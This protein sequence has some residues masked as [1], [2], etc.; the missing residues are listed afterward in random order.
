MN[1]DFVTVTDGPFESSDILLYQYYRDV[2]PELTQEWTDKSY[3]IHFKTD[4]KFEKRGF[5]AFYKLY[6]EREIV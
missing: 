2:V 6:E 1:V 3:W 4:S 5:K